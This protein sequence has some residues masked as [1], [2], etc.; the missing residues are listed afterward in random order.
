MKRVF[1]IILLAVLAGC[2]T[3]PDIFETK[4]S[5]GGIKITY[6]QTF[7]KSL[8]EIDK[9]FKDV[10]ACTGITFQKPDVRISRHPGGHA[11]LWSQSHLSVAVAKTDDQLFA[12]RHEF[13]HFSLEASGMTY[14]DNFNHR[15]NLFK[16]CG[17]SYELQNFMNDI[18]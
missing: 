9:A 15:S 4:I 7:K 6:P 3:V 13:I 16:K 5:P 10:V 18:F 14:E 17:P 2:A 11:Q 12:L 1:F 8:D